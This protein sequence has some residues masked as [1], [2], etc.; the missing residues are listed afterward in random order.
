V[1]RLDYYDADVY[2]TNSHLGQEDRDYV[3]AWLR[4]AANGDGELASQAQF[5][6]KFYRP[7]PESEAV[8]TAESPEA[9]EALAADGT[10][11]APE[12]DDAPEADEADDGYDRVAIPPSWVPDEEAADPAL[13]FSRKVRTTV[14]SG[15][16]FETYLN[17]KLDAA[18]E[19]DGFR[20]EQMG[21]V[22]E[23][24]DLPAGCRWAPSAARSVVSAE[25]ANDV[26]VPSAWV[27]WI[28]FRVGEPAGV[29][30][31]LTLDRAEAVARR[32][33][34]AFDVTSGVP[35]L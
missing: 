32:A 2:L 15:S 30:E 34:I 5:V 19:P 25:V 35:S 3:L 33:A 6:L 31:W 20:I 29:D 8:A 18:L 24:G 4:R 12:A 16:T 9:A 10:D 17:V 26:K 13:W 11:L 7:E 27:G 28:P 22:V 23:S 14:E 1:L 21:Q